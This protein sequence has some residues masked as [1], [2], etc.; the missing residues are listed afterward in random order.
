MRRY[1]RKPSGEFQ[2][3]YDTCSLQFIAL[4]APQV[5]AMAG[6]CERILQ[7]HE[8]PAILEDVE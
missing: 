5:F 3:N 1:W 4:T 8:Q 6:L 2:F 7:F